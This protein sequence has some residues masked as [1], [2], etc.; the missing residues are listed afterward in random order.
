MKLFKIFA[1]VIFAVTTISSFTMSVANAAGTYSISCKNDAYGM[2]LGSDYTNIAYVYN[3]AFTGDA[4]AGSF[5]V[6]TGGGLGL[7]Y[8]IRG[9]AGAYVGNDCIYS[10]SAD[11]NGTAVVAGDVARLAVNAI[12]GAV[13]NRIDMAYAAKAS[14]ASATGL[15]FS[16]LDDGFAMAANKIV[17]GLS[18]W[19]D[20]GN[21]NVENNQTF[22]GVRLDSMNYD[23]DA[24]SYSVGVDKVFGKALVG[25]VVSNL[26]TDF[27]TT[28]NDGT[29]KQSIDTY[30]M[31]VAYKTS[32]LQIDLGFGQGY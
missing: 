26:D 5:N 7:Q 28:F 32:V 8:L 30:G 29:Y 15:S 6:D 2:H 18:F 20:I 23:G 13:S 25:I 22:T 31:Y 17:G 10:G 3:S 16:T 21:T 24:S 9:T 12:V 14:S 11:T 1:A 27:K 19:G 4:Y